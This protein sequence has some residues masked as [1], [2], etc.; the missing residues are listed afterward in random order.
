MIFPKGCPDLFRNIACGAARTHRARQHRICNRRPGVFR[1]SLYADNMSPLISP[2]SGASSKEFVDRGSL[3]LTRLLIDG[4]DKI[5]IELAH[6]R[7]EPSPIFP[8]RLKDHGAPVS[9]D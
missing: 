8:Q 2:P 1:P 3:L 7:I 4:F 5:V 9:S 6:K